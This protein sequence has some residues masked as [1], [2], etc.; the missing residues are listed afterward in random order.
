ML[1]RHLGDEAFFKSLNHYLKKHAFQSVEV[2]DLRIAFEEVTGLDLN[3]FFN[4]WFLASGH[5]TL[6]YEVDYSQAD[7]LLLTSFPASGFLSNSFVQDSIQGELVCKRRTT[8]K[9]T[10]N[11]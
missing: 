5:P 10:G 1:R 3:W 6:E 8:R 2:H 7:N 9:G 4:Q 11:G